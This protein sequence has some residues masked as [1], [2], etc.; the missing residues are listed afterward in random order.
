MQTRKPQ[1]SPITAGGQVTA[2]GQG[3]TEPGKSLESLSACRV[4]C[5]RTLFLP[6]WISRK[7]GEIKK[8]F[9]N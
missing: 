5:P 6:S 4:D 3:A 2:Y 8:V 7:I 1:V 9:G